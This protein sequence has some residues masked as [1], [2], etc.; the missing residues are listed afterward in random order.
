MIAQ[1]QVARR[2]DVQAGQGDGAIQL[3]FQEMHEILDPLITEQSVDAAALVLFQEPALPP[4]RGKGRLVLAPGLHE[5]VEG[6]VIGAVALVG[7]IG[8]L[9][10]AIPAAQPADRLAHHR[11]HRE[12]GP[13]RCRFQKR[14]DEPLVALRRGVFQDRRPPMVKADSGC[15]ADS[16]A[17]EP[18]FGVAR[19]TRRWSKNTSMSA[20][21][22]A[23]PIHRPRVTVH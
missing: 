10:K 21:G 13:A 5:F 22:F 4:H 18:V 9:A 2:R 20:S 11:R 17:V 7:Q 3:V 15:R 8:A 16:M 6:H 14:P 1:R 19:K 12:A 23:R